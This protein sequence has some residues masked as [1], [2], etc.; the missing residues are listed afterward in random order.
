V[1]RG[2]G[3]SNAAIGIH[4][5]AQDS[6]PLIM[7]VGQVGSDTVDREA[8]QEIDYRRM[9][10]SVAKWV[11]QIDR[12]ERIPE[13]IAHAY[14]VAQSGRPGPV[15]LALPEDVSTARVTCH[16]A[17][18][19]DAIGSA[20]DHG[21]VDAVRA[22]LEQAIG[23]LLIVGGSRWDAAACQALRAFAE[24]TGLP[25]ACAFRNQDLFDNRH[26]NYAGDVGIGINPKLAARVKDADVLLVIHLATDDERALIRRLQARAKTENRA[27]DANEETI[28]HRLTVYHDETAPVLAYYPKSRVAKVDAIGTPLE[29]LRETLDV[30]IPLQL[31]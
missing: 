22:A 17:P 20:P 30:L 7:F 19:V 16:D 14:R 4:T 15:V 3:A 21:Q 9:Y 8:F 27:D 18:R 29:V 1:T 23:P 24:G 28:R 26:P 6:T 5:A 2:P 11:A 25:V 12:A 13:Y 31:G 10:G